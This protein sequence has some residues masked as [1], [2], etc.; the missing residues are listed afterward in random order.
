M[1]KR[2]KIQSGFTLIEILLVIGLIAILATMVIVAV[3]PARQYAQARNTQRWSNVNTILN[4]V[5]QY[6]VDNKGAL[7][8]GITAAE[9]EICIDGT[10]EATCTGASLTPLNELALDEM[11]IVSIPLDPSC[12]TGCAVNG[13]GY[14]ILRTVNGRITVAAPDAELGE[15]ISVTR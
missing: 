4:S 7:P 1:F 11:Y 5:H 10:A 9:E 2:V 12:P 3:N 6:L 8:P 13:V 14:T 15:V